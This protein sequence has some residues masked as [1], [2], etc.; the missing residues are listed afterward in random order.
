MDYPKT[1]QYNNW[2][3]H[4]L[5]LTKLQT[6]VSFVQL[7][8]VK[9]KNVKFHA[10]YTWDLYLIFLPVRSLYISLIKGFCNWN[11]QLYMMQ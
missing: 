11:K 6:E 9:N 10:E 8:I 5:K 2:Q 1:T 7:K 3:K 4:N